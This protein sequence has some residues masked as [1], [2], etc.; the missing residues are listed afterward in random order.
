MRK[1]DRSTLRRVAF[2]IGH[3]GRGGAEA[4]ISLLAQGLSG[5]GIEVHMFLISKSGP[6]EAVLRDAGIE[7][8]HL[9]FGR[10]SSGSA[11]LLR[12]LR[13]F[14]RLI[15][16]L[17]HIRPE[18]LHAYLFEGRMLGPP[19]AWLAGVPVMVAGRRNAGEPEQRHRRV[20]VLE[21]TMTRLTDH[22][23]TNAVAVAEEARAITKIPARKLSVIYNGLRASAFERAEPA[24]IEDT[25]LPV[26]LCVARLAPQKGHDILIEAAS[27]LLRRGRP[28]TFLL[29]GEGRERHR[30]EELVRGSRVD[31]RFL[32]DR[33]DVKA[34]L[35][36]ADVVVLPSLWEGLSNAVMEAMAAGRPIVATAVGGTPELLDGRGVLI[37]ASDAEALAD[38][39][40]RVLDDPDLAAC[41][42]R[43]ARAWAR[44]HLDVD[45]LVDQH[46]N[47]Y[48]RLALIRKDC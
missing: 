28:C 7:V 26:V 1:R 10:T 31:V 6:H 18:V 4:Q 34:L 19:A 42:G 44:E 40:V 29:A 27:R 8:H 43:E 46:I 15:R 23:V 11:D 36:R 20:L 12:C 41:L 22:V 13:G 30:L 24:S 38:G 45:V 14:A 35:A 48:Q 2:L 17:R 37:P 25:E 39:I 32:G 16:S 5:R 3:L 47:L 33:T 9:G 21:R